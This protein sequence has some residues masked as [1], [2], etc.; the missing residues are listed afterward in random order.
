MLKKIE[1]LDDLEKQRIYLETWR[2]SLIPLC[3]NKSQTAPHLCSD[4]I[5]SLSNRGLC[6][7]K[8][9]AP[10]NEIYRPTEYMKIFTGTFL[11]N[12]DNFTMLKSMGSGRRY[13]TSFLINANRIMDLRNGV[14]W[15]QSKQ[16]EFR[17]GI[18][19]NYDMP[20]IRDSSIK[21]DAG[22]KTTINVNAIQLESDPSIEDLGIDRRKCKFRFESEGMTIFKTYSRYISVPD[23]ILC[24]VI[25]N[26]YTSRSGL[27]LTSAFFI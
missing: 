22:F 9:Q 27:N 18:N 4:F 7:T 6:F 3:T 21:I 11:N 10:V 26:Y 8:N 15:N 2:D 13:K 14:E 19:P 24:F 12:R 16:A 25:H 5:P 1:Q 17:L 23:Y 20:E